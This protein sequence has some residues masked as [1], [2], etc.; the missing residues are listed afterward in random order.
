MGTDAMMSF[1]VESK[2][3]DRIHLPISPEL[4][5]EVDEWRRLQPDIPARAP[6]IRRL[7]EIAL[8]VEAPGGLKATGKPGQTEPPDGQT[9]G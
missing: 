4:A 9:S 7:L 8:K 1:M 2:N 6:A 5:R 3:S